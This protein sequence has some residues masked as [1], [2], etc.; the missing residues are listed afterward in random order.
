MLIQIVSNWQIQT[1]TAMTHE[2]FSV[3][4]GHK[5]ITEFI[6]KKH[7]SHR[8]CRTRGT[9]V[10]D[11]QNNI[12]SVVVAGDFGC[13]RCTAQGYPGAVR[14]DSLMSC[15]ADWVSSFTCKKM[16]TQVL[17]VYCCC[18]W[19]LTNFEFQHLIDWLIDLYSYTYQ[20]YMYTV[21][22]A[23]EKTITNKV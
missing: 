14:D 4:H 9:I 3:P 13:H 17:F 21:P 11:L 18:W 16:C 12:S 19:I 6:D 23:K 1:M 22:I 15:T 10:W 20:T 2:Q 7:E 5:I 8:P